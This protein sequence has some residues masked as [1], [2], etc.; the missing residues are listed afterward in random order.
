MKA[1]NTYLLQV[2][3]F[4]RVQIVSEIDVGELSDESI[5]LQSLK[6]RRIVMEFVIG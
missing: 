4:F 2:G 5:V 3:E 1:F 6:V